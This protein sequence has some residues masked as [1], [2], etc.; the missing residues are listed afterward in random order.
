MVRK[1]F[2]YYS[3]LIVCLSFIPKENY[4]IDVTTSPSKTFYIGFVNKVRFNKPLENN[5][6]IICSDN[7]FLRKIDELN[8]EVLNSGLDD[9]II[10]IAVIKNSDTTIL[11]SYCFKSKKAPDPILYY[12]NNPLYINDS[13]QPI[14]KKLLQNANTFSIKLDMDYVTADKFFRLDEEVLMVKVNQKQFYQQIIRDTIY[15][16]NS[17]EI[18]ITEN[19]LLNIETYNFNNVKDAIMQAPIGSPLIISNIISDGTFSVA[20]FDSITTTIVE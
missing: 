11:Q 12:G 16:G 19:N 3:L 6:K 10:K 4:T 1:Y 17:M 5:H 8:Y 20:I 9:V 13:I 7:A 15:D 18:R 14:S 2:I